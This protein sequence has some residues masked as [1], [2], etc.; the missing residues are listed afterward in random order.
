MDQ[1]RATRVL[2]V[3]GGLSGLATACFLARA[4]QDVT[5]YERSAR[6]GG[7]AQTTVRDGFA[8]NLGPHAIYTGGAM[9]SALADLDVSYGTKHGPR[10]LR[11]LHD[12]S[13]S[14]MPDSATT[15]LRSRA[16]TWGDR[17]ELVGLMSKLPKLQATDFADTSIAAWIEQHTKRPA[18]RRLFG[19]L[20]STAVYCSNREL[21]SADVFVDKMQRSLTHPIHYVDGGWQIIVD[22]LAARAR[23][24][25]VTIHAES[26]IRDVVVR[27][28]GITGVATS[29]GDFIGADSVVLAV[30]PISA[31]KLYP[32]R[33]ADITAPLRPAIV[34]ALDIALSTLP[35]VRDTV[36][37]DL[38]QPRFMS[39]QSQFAAVAP[40]GGALITAFKQLDPS[41]TE[42]DHEKDLETLLDTTQP[43]WRDHILHRQFLPT[44]HAVGALPLA[45]NGGLMG[46]PDVQVKDALGLYL[47]GDWVG[48]EGFLSDAC[49][50]SAKRVSD[51][52][53]SQPRRSRVGE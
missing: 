29:G 34:A 8:I 31:R 11:V 26:R 24:L 30:D 46:R 13:T 2:V 21:V 22:A 25:G 9:T 35:N 48:S 7:R 42:G 38:D 10:G 50:A 1:H 32:D 41:D 19:A 37:Q 4:G 40:R 44:I 12:G 16:L 3:G 18:V 5:L 17:L 20:A 53:S 45:S 28:G 36:V 6:L 27:D 15:L 47:T 23:D 52:I 33:L 39:T 49:F 51:L 43:G 14:L